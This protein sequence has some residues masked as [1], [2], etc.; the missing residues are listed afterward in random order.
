MNI[1]LQR[2]P[3]GFLFMNL[4]EIVKAPPIDPLSYPYSESPAWV[5]FLSA[6]SCN[7]KKQA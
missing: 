5:S 2:V 1:N 6:G 7:T 3:C 4:L